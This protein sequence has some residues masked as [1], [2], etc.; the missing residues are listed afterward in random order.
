MISWPIRAA[1]Q[2]CLVKVPLAIVAI[3]V[4]TSCAAT[5]RV[6]R[7]TVRQLGDVP[8][9]A[10]A[11]QEQA[12]SGAP[13]LQAIVVSDESAK[14]V[15]DVWSTV[16]GAGQKKEPID[17]QRCMAYGQSIGAQNSAMAAPPLVPGRTY[18]VF[19]NARFADGTEPTFGFSA[20]FCITKDSSGRTAVNEV[21][22]DEKA[23]RWNDDVCGISA[24]K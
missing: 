10:I 8:C 20:R 3:A 17:A 12:R 6:G 14:P 2:T 15:A 4:W 24:K 18:G 9:F 7:A 13:L 23:S 11:S 16:L 22:W 19:I 21:L 1:K 5:S